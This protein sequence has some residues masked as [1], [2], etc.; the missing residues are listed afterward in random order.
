MSNDSYGNLGDAS[1]PAADGV[2]CSTEISIVAASSATLIAALGTIG[3]VTTLLALGRNRA[4]RQRRRQ[5]TTAFVMSLATADLLFC[6]AVMPLMALRYGRRRWP[7]TSSSLWCR[8]FPVALY[9]TVATSVLSLVALTVN[10]YVLIV[11]PSWYGSIYRTAGMV[12]LQ[13]AVCWAIPYG[14]MALPLFELW[15]RLGFDRRTFS[16]TVLPSITSTGTFSA[17]PKKFIFIV[18]FALPFCAIVLCYTAIIGAVRRQRRNMQRYAVKGSVSA[19]ATPGSMAAGPSNDD[20]E[21]H[22]T[23]TTAAIF[24]CFMICFLPLT[25]AN[26]LLE[27]AESAGEAGDVHV[28]ASILTWHSAVL[29]PFIY[30][31][32]SRHYRNAYWA[33]LRCSDCKST[34]TQRSIT[35]HRQ[36]SAM[37]P[38][39]TK[40]TKIGNCAADNTTGSGTQNNSEV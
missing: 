33:V 9:G 32:G 2:F 35:F 4:V 27:D 28:L 11:H 40:S 20:D 12:P 21:R 19:T 30:A 38:G 3:N 22:L 17:S 26:V 34:N 37:T 13:L 14:L 29:N 15:G 7:F 18:G 6:V 10:R 23:R 8:L 24:G 39:V 1:N 36:Q 25:I 16:C 31:L 5:P